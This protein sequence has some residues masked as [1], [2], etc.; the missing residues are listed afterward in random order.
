MITQ[1]LTTV[2]N[3]QAADTYL[4]KLKETAKIAYAPRYAAELQG[5]SR[6]A[7]RPLPGGPSARPGSAVASA[8]ASAN[9]TGLN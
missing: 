8:R 6:S 2:R 1:Y 5:V 7:A 4:K 3:A 9:S